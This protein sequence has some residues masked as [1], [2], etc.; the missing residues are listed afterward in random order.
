[1]NVDWQSTLKRH[2][3]FSALSKKEV[4]YLIEVSDE[5]DYARDDVVI[6]EG[7][8]GNSIFIIGFGA[9]E[10]VL[11]WRRE[12][13]LHLATL[14][15]GE[16][17]GE[18]A[19]FEKP[20]RRSATVIAAERCV[21]LEIDGAEFLTVARNHPEIVMGVIEKVTSR[22]RDIGDHVLKVNLRDMDE[23]IDTLNTRLDAELRATG[24]T[25]NATQT[26]FDQTSRRANEII[27]SAERSR[28]RLTTT[29]S[30]LGTGIT[31]LVAVFGYVGFSQLQ[32]VTSL[33]EVIED[34]ADKIDS[35]KAE[36][37]RDIAN[38]K[39]KIREIDDMAP[40]V[41]EATE[42]LELVDQE[43]VRFYRKIML[44]RFYDELNE[45]IEEAKKMYQAMLQM[46]DA[47]VT[48]EM[49]EKINLRL[50]NNALVTK[51]DDEDKFGTDRKEDE[52]INMLKTDDGGKTPR[53]ELLS[54][55]AILLSY[56]INAER[57]R[58]QRTLRSFKDSAERH[59][60]SPIRDRLPFNIGDYVSLN[61]IQ[62]AI[63]SGFK[64]DS[65]SASNI[66]L[67]VRI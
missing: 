20:S 33:T 63:A 12:H 39:D 42:K 23:K 64:L 8:H 36:L 59:R 56:T 11:P 45:D 38:V 66:G 16:F 54:Y 47:R 60:N 44:P 9:V 15:K 37:D 52:I 5:K 49:F 4:D 3:I 6:R 31:A 28:T 29:A 34:K 17:F 41:A 13:T 62:A 35:I 27:E 14:G 2:S 10:V 21:L 30:I 51:T 53:Q 24:A 55:F 22:L 1:M 19:L 32:N 46:R 67:P 18:L 40:K 25:L 57:D 26:V 7:E 65:Y 50:L 43:I 48:N 58:V 61:W